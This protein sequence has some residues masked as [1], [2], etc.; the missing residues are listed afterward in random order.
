M[1]EPRED[2]QPKL[3]RGAILSAVF[4]AGV[5][6]AAYVLVA[7]ALA[8]GGPSDSDNEWALLLGKVAVGVGMAM[9]LVAFVLA[10]ASRVR[11]EP[12][13]T[14]WFA[15]ALLPALIAVVGLVYVF[16]TR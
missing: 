11:R 4:A 10:S 16:G 8:V 6:P 14:L 12:I 15:F 2:I 3:G 9:A 13:D 5:V 7:L 1:F